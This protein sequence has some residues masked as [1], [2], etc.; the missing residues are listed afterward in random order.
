MVP[1]LVIA[2]FMERRREQQKDK[3]ASLYEEQRPKTKE[4]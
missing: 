4:I 3:R 1:T 2:K